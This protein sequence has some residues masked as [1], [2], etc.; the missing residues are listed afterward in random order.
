MY[1]LNVLRATIRLALW[2]TGVDSHGFSLAFLCPL[3]LEGQGCMPWPIG[4][5]HIA[6]HGCLLGVLLGLDPTYTVSESLLQCL[7]G[8]GPDDNF[9]VK[10]S[11]LHESWGWTKLLAFWEI[12]AVC[13]QVPSSAEHC[14][15]EGCAEVCLWHLKSLC[16]AVNHLFCVRKQPWGSDP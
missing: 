3:F 13:Q 14:L 12:Q 1:I 4:C 11:S 9:R 16:S 7:Q 5:C 8:S 15:L 10:P 2:C 6:N